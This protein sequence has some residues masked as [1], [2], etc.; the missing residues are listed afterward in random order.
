MDIEFLEDDLVMGFRDRSYDWRYA[1]NS[2]THARGDV[3]RACDTGGG[4]VLE[5]GGSCGGVA[6]SGKVWGPGDGEFFNDET[7]ILNG[8][9]VEE[10]SAMGA[11]ATAG[12]EAL[13]TDRVVTTINDPSTLVQG[14]LM[15]WSPADGSQL[16]DYEVFRGSPNGNGGEAPVFGKTNGLGDIESDCLLEPLPIE[17]GSLTA[18]SSGSGIIVEWST[19]SETDNSGFNVQYAA[20][21]RPFVDAGWID[22]AGNTT[23]VQ[24]YSFS[25]T[26]AFPG[27]N[28]V[29]LQHVGF[30]GSSNNSATIEVSVSLPAGFVLRDAY[31]NPFT[32]TATVQFAVTESQPVR[33]ELFNAQG[34]RINTIFSGVA[35]SE[36]V[37]EAT[38]D[39]TNL[40]SGIYFVRMNGVAFTTVK[41]ITVV[42]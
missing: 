7:N 6:G 37:I 30:D 8:V 39:G 40:P 35:N 23:A 4:W 17:L 19:L 26:D 24:N 25:I 21:G 36:E 42:R 34:L 22:G 16:E 2:A 10:N 11:L 13:S 32:G 5:N 1:P 15:Y 20:P 14:G 41:T 29:R 3:L 12:I 27:R 33:V 9:L 31:P 38:V 28:L 18:Y